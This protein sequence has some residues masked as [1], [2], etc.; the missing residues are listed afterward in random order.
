[1]SKKSKQKQSK[2]TLLDRMNSSE[3]T[4]LEHNYKDLSSDLLNIL[5]LA[6]ILL[7]LLIV[8]AVVDSRIGFLTGYATRLLDFI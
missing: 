2:R 6:T 3:I 1:M 4:L 8:I 5:I 7:G